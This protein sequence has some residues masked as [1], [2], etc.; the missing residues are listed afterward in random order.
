MGDL[1]IIQTIEKKILLRD[2]KMKIKFAQTL[3]TDGKKSIYRQTHKIKEKS[4]FFN[5]SHVLEMLCLY[6]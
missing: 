5:S 3:R 6:L 2:L 4:T 1:D